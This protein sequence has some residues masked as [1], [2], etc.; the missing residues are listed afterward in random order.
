MSLLLE[1]L[2]TLLPLVYLAACVAYGAH[3]FGKESE[4][5]RAG[6][7]FLVSGLALH[8]GFLVTLTLR[9][10]QLPAA[11]A[12]QALS[13]IAFAVG[14][15]YLVVEWRS[16]DRSTGFWS[17]V[18]VFLLQLLASLLWDPVPPDLRVFRSPL[19]STHVALALVGYAAFTLAAAYGYLFLRL[20]GELKQRTFRTFFGRL[21]ALETLERMMSTALVTG[22][23][24]YTLALTAGT[25]WAQRLSL[26]DWL[27]EPWT[28]TSLAI[29]LLYAVALTLR[30]IHRWQGR[31]TAIA[32]LLG[33]LLILASL[34]AVHLAA[35]GF[36]QF[37]Q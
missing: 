28:V 10:H 25:L 24:S 29:W 32:S 23:L 20:Y 7:L 1:G 4:R 5:R 34:V 19:F 18:P 21:P 16:G 27:S 13:G 36:H 3:F 12:G 11:T 14:L 37:R 9:Y 30:R 15:V 2:R 6:T 33:I 26:A 22:F 8:L 17:V 31:H 35:E